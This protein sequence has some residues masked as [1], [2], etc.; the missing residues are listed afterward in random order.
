MGSVQREACCFKGERLMAVYLPKRKGIKS[1][2][3][4][5]EFCYL[6]ERYQGSTGATTRT[7]AL[8]VEKRERV[9][10]ER[11][12][13]GLPAEAVSS[14][15]RVVS[16][17]VDNYIEGYKVSH[18]QSS[19]DYVQKRLRHVQR[20]LGGLRL[21]DL[22]EDCILNY[23][24]TRKHEKASGRTINMELGELSRAM[25]HTWRELWPK[26]KKLEERKDIG[27]ALSPE[28]QDCVLD[29]AAKLRSPVVR[30]AIPV[31]LLTGMRPGE[32]MSLRWLQ[33][34][35]VARTITV[36]RAKTSSGTGRI[37]P[38]NDDL[39]EVL[40]AHRLWFVRA[41]G[42][43][44]PDHCVL[45]FGSPQPTDPYRPVTDISSGWDLI[46]KR[47]GVRCRPHDLRHTFCTHLA[48][49]GVPESTMLALMGHMS[50][51]M[52]ERYSHIRMAAK[53]EAVSGV[54]LRRKRAPGGDL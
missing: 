48:E 15:I 33:I 6:G 2:F 17:L 19:I 9:K 49:D 42:E 45:P 12:H 39:L 43:P 52:L 29:E 21:S 24:R 36:G 1:K 18:R 26:V 53:R 28:Q 51:A 30:T 20:L 41:F 13:A 3:Y 4:V 5:F 46:R 25:G 22:T 38:I 40:V 27:Q 16:K 34:N 8:A 7:L 44:K 47:S 50:R 35:L 32:A 37:I 54:R 10:A 14:R 31:L 23:I 11:D